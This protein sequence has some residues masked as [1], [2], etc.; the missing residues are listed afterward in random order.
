MVMSIKIF[1]DG[2]NLEEMAAAQA[3]P[4]ISGL[5]CNPSLMRKAGVRDYRAFAADVLR[6][7]TKPISFEVFSDEW[8]EMERQARIIAGWGPNVYCKIP[9]TNTRGESACPLIGVLAETG[10]KVNV[11][12]VFTEQQARDAAGV[13]GAS[14]AI[15]SVFAGRIADAGVDPMPICWQ[16]KR[17]AG[18]NTEILWASAREIF[19][20]TQA[21]KSDCDIITLSPELIA[22]LPLAGKDLDEYS[23]ETV[24]M[25]HRDAAAAGYVL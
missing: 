24:K 10:V 25:F 23:L 13:L 9:I 2:A 18:V 19:N 12:A 20:L 11:T 4:L 3:N 5:T 21:Q 14:R 15:I 22:K 7:V 6:I 16:A 1:S 8:D 17:C